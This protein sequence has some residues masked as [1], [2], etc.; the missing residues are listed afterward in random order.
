MQ[1]AKKLIEDAG[2]TV[3]VLI[4]KV[5]NTLW[6]TYGPA[7]NLAYLIGKDQ[8]VIIAQQWYNSREMETAIS[9]LD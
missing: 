2:I 6:N 4:D 1:L 3:P 7:P 5:D 8:K 9:R